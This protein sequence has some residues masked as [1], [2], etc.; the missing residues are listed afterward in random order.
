[1]KNISNTK[2]T[3]LIFLSYKWF[4]FFKYLWSKIGSMR[5]MELGGGLS[6]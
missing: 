2:I 1:M 6:P 4:W 3:K 5:I